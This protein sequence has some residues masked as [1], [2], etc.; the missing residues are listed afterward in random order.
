MMRRAIALALFSGLLFTA[1]FTS[2][3]AATPKDLP[4]LTLHTLDGKTVTTADLKGKVVLLDFWASWCIP[5]RKSFPEVDKLSR[6]FE[7]KGLTVIAVSVDEQRKNAE[8]FLSQYPH[9]MTI[10]LDD[11]GT[12]AQAFDLQG[13]PSSLI[14]DRTGHIRYTHMGY[15]DKTIAQFRTEIAQLLAEA[16]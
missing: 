16:R 5:C 6:E 8:S 7:Q 13:M 10:A 3:A 11:K 1:L 4:S 2:L 9:S 12:A 14:V 15:T